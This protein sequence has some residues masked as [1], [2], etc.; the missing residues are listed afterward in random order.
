M[1]FCLPLFAS[2]C[3]W[4]NHEGT[5]MNLEK[6][7]ESESYVLFLSISCYQGWLVICQIFFRLDDCECEIKLSSTAMSKSIAVFNIHNWH[8]KS[9]SS[10]DSHSEAVIN[11]RW[12]GTRSVLSMPRFYCKF[13]LYYSP[14]WR[15]VCCRCNEVADTHKWSLQTHTL[16]WCQCSMFRSCEIHM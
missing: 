6:A 8:Q 5:N 10:V 2:F 1:Y 16:Q 15:G 14:V 9:Q 7:W 3:T 11:A 4:R 12:I 13:F